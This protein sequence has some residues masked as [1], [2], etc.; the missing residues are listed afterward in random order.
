[1]SKNSD[2]FVSNWVSANVHNIPGL[3]DYSDHVAQLAEQLIADAEARGI[4][5]DELNETIGDAT[6]FLTDAYERV[7]DGTLGFRDSGD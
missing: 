4:A 2:V 5:E 3:E 6:D 1:M 7:Q